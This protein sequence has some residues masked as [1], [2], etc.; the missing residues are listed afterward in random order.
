MLLNVGNAWI[1]PTDV[2]AVIPLRASGKGAE[3]IKD[4][5]V[6]HTRKL[7][8]VIVEFDSWNDA[9]NVANSVGNAVSQ[10][11]GIR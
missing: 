11:A 2:E 3:K 1:D 10:Q 9:V 4:R 8:P 6:V 7:G 5:V